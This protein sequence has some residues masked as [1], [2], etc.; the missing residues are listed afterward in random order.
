MTA[1]RYLLDVGLYG[2]SRI[3]HETI[4]I[5]VSTLSI[6]I[7]I[8]DGRCVDFPV[9]RF[10]SKWVETLVQISA[11]QVLMRKM[12]HSS[13]SVSL[14]N[15]VDIP[16]IP[17][18]RVLKLELSSVIWNKNHPGVAIAVTQNPIPIA[19]N[20]KHRIS[21]LFFAILTGSHISVWTPLYADHRSQDT[22]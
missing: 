10:S 8:G 11:M 7:S 1:A 22:C 5:A 13:L 18:K 19:A 6:F 3:K 21:P 14:L 4:N 2:V 17:G 20:T 9:F 15:W 16:L 12:P